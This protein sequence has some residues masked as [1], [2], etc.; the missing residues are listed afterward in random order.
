MIRQST[1]LLFENEE[2]QEVHDNVEIEITSKKPEGNSYYPFVT[3]NLTLQSD[4]ELEICL[5]DL[6]ENDEVEIPSRGT[7]LNQQRGFSYSFHF[8]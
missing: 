2:I 3:I 6:C 4:Q 5:L 8:S 1:L 7:L